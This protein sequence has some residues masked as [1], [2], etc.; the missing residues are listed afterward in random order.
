MQQLLTPLTLVE[1]PK[2]DVSRDDVM[3]GEWGMIS[4][5]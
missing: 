3:V 4:S 2:V 5:D 1:Q